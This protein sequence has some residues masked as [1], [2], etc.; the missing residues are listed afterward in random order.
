MR[1]HILSFVAAFFTLAAFYLAGV[2]LLLDPVRGG[3]APSAQLLPLPL[4]FVVAIAVYIAL[5]VWIERMI[6]APFKAAMVIVLS[7]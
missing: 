3:D 2:L 7:Q 5:F 4:A 1:A 6:G